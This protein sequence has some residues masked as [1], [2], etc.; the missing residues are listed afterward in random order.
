MPETPTSES[1]SRTSSS[2]KGLMTAVINFI[3]FSVKKGY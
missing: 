2:L 1:A 3:R